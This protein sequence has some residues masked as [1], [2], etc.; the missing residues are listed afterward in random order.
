MLAGLIPLLES[1]GWRVE[2][3]DLHDGERR[4]PVDLRQIGKTGERL[5]VIV[6]GCEQLGILSRFQLK[7]CCRR[8]GWGLIVTAHQSSGLPELCDTTV[9]LEQAKRVVG[10]L[11]EKSEYKVSAKNLEE[12]YARSEGNLRELLFDLYDLFEQERKS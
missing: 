7:R 6:D 2:R 1:Q 3:I 8:R 5:L 4:L 12:R 9:S 10:E 11:L